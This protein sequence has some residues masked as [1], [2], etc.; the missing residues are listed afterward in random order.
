MS[1]K[2]AQIT[3]HGTNVG[4][5]ITA[6]SRPTREDLCRT[7][8]AEPGTYAAELVDRFYEFFVVRAVDVCAEYEQYYRVEYDSV[9]QFLYLKHGMNAESVEAIGKTFRPGGFL[10]IAIESWGRD[11]QMEGLLS[12]GEEVLATLMSAVGAKWAENEL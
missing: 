5:V 6:R 1:Q 2:K 11:W 7:A 10:A 8:K 3:M 12:Y 9:A 4:I